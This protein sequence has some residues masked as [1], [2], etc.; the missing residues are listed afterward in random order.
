MSLK[1]LLDPRSIAIIGVTNDPASTGTTVMQHMRAG[2]KRA[3]YPV[4][5]TEHEILDT[6]TFTSVGEIPHPI[7]LAVIAVPAQEVASVLREC[8]HKGADTA[9]ILSTGFNEA[10]GTGTVL[11]EEI[12][13][14]AKENGMTVLGPSSLGV[15]CT[16]THWNASTISEPP[17]EGSVAFVSRSSSF[18][19][20]LFERATRDGVGF[21]TFVTIGDGVALSEADILDHLATDRATHAV[22]LYLE[23]VSDGP[24]LLEALRR[25]TKKKPVVILRAGRTEATAEEHALVPTD[26]VLDAAL[27]QTGALVVDSDRV[28]FS[29]A[30]LFALGLTE[31]CPRLMLVESVGSSATHAIDRINSSHSLSLATITEDTQGALQTLIDPTADIGNPLQVPADAS[32]EVFASLLEVLVD[33]AS[34]DAILLSLPSE[35]IASTPTFVDDLRTYSAKKPIIPLC[36]HADATAPEVTLLTHAGIPVFDSPADALEALDNL[37]NGVPK[38]KEEQAVE[39]PRLSPHLAMYPIEDMQTI[40]ANYDLPLRGVFVREKDDIERALGKLGEGPY[41]IKAIS[42]EL[43]HKHD[44][45]AVLLSLTDKEAIDKAWDKILKQVENHTKG[46]T[47][48]GMLVQTM[49]TGIE[50]TVSMVRDATVGATVVFG[51]GGTLAEVLEDRAIRVLPIDKDEAKIMISEIKAYPLLTGANDTEPCDLDALAELIASLSHLALDYPEIQEV[52]FDPVFAT[53]K[54]TNIVDARVMREE[55]TKG[56]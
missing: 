35:L 47:I 22:L 42:R 40:L 39:T 48:D 33:Q 45:G 52:D 19:T 38:E 8:A 25:T 24:G 49:V 28:F 9:L 14:I 2:T 18:G 37:A 29:F 27:A 30:K 7:D 6:P 23:Q 43:V 44:L 20:T 46:A 1:T 36:I 16:H 31:P 41:A 15:V 32:P 12:A 10:D 50:C 4:S 11:L 51:L 17:R 56:E 55:G 5:S 53:P 21:S 54:G 34:I 26:D 13:T 3:V